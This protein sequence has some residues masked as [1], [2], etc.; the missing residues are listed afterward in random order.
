VASVANHPGVL[1]RVAALFSRRGYNISS[2]AV[3]ETED[4]AISRMTIVVDADDETL[5]Q[6]TKQLHKLI[7]VLKVTD[8]TKAETVNRELALVKVAASAQNRAEISQ[9]VDIFRARIVDISERSV[10]VEL[11]GDEGK[12]EAMI[13]LL[14]PYGIKEIARTGKISMVRSAKGKA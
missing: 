12:A 4:P 8:V 3:G 14:R 7:E 11:T 1:A 2:L 10:V 5:E 9:I 6:I 13:Q